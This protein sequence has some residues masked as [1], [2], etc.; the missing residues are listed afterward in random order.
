MTR[1]RGGAG[2]QGPQRGLP[3]R[4]PGGWAVGAWGLAALGFLLGRA[5]LLGVPGLYGLALVCALGAAGGQAA[6]AAAAGAALGS[7]SLDV[8]LPARLAG[9][10]ALLAAL[11]LPRRAGAAGAALVASALAAL[12]PVWGRP[13]PWVEAVRMTLAVALVAAAAHILAQG[14]RGWREVRPS[15]WESE[16]AQA[17]V[18][19]TLGAATGWQGLRIPLPNGEGLPLEVAGTSLAVMV[20]AWAGGSLLAAATGLLL[21]T[22]GLLAGTDGLAG[23]PRYAL[24]AVAF[25]VAGAVAGC[26]RVL[27]RPGVALAYGLAYLALGGGQDP[28]GI[29]GPA[30]AVAAAAV[31]LHLVPRRLGDAVG[32]WLAGAPPAVG[33]P[34]DPQPVPGGTVARLAAVAAVLREV[35]AAVANGRPAAEEEVSLDGVLSQV[36]DLACDRCPLHNLCWVQNHPRTRQA[37]VAVWQQLGPGGGSSPALPAA[38][39]EVCSYPRQVLVAMGAVREA[40]A[41]AAQHRR[42]AEEMR[43]TLG[44]QVAGL[45]DVVERLVTEAGAA[46]NAPPGAP[47]LQVRT[48]VARLAKRGSLVC[49]DSFL[50][51]PAGQAGFALVLSDG[52]GAGRMAAQESQ[53]TVQMVHRLLAAGYRLEAAVQTVNALLLVKQ[54]EDWF[55]TLDVA[56]IDLTDG[57]VEFAKL[58]AAPSIVRR[59]TGVQVIRG[60]TPPAGV[61]HPVPVDPEW[62]ILRPGDWIVMATDGLW[63]SGRTPVGSGHWL[64]EFVASASPSEPRGLAE[65][66]L[67]RA[68]AGA[69]GEP[70]DDMTVLVAQVVAP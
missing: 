4:R 61:L 29:G 32:R 34:P 15:L 8:P 6:W 62:R 70:A 23:L 28:L 66:I 55:A 20:A 14:W 63:E 26:F 41:V 68:L 42:R 2:R 37:F 17:A 67:A 16:A 48:G 10:G 56:Y 18:I 3:G 53:R 50:A 36:V 52:M 60:D 5:P 24:P 64:V 25:G 51:G 13:L 46:P 38:L 19:L 27:G 49:G 31:A 54:A 40:Q 12:V 1:Q 22:A 30:A 47:R 39:Q 59:H 9:G 11:V 33:R 43:R 58:G 7:W 69:A 57:R 44:L 65:A 21:G 35:E 45:A